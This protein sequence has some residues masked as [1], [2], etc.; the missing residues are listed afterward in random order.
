MPSDIDNPDRN[1][2]ISHEVQELISYRPRWF[3]RNG[4][5]IFFFVLLLALGLTW[6]IDY[7]DAVK[8][9]LKLLYG[10][11]PQSQYYGQMLVPRAGFEKV[12]PGQRVR[13]EV[14][15]YPVKEWGYLSG[16]VNHISNVPTD[17]DSLLI[18][19]YLPDGLNTNYNKGIFFHDNLDA[20][21]EIKTDNR[22]LFDR[23]LD[24]VR[25]RPKP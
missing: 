12:R 2:L 25:N 24:G 13:I 18:S 9:D 19:I 10:P 11:P 3:I 7:P 14:D 21:A 8:G 4:N 6:F 22:R 16:S 1:A 20:R 17:K 15:G 5:A 23:L